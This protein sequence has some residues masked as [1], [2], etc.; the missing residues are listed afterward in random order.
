VTPADYTLR[1]TTQAH[2][3]RT[4]VT[5][6]GEIDLTNADDFA[7]EITHLPGPGP[8][9][10]DFTRLRYLDSAGFAVLDPMLADGTIV[11][12]LP[13]TSPLRKAADLVGLPCHPRIDLVP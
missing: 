6:T 11:I 10:V 2:T 9:I 1:R 13:P 12:V 8:T 4:V 5:V 7:T 3:G